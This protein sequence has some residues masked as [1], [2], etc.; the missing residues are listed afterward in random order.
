MNII[1]V[2]MTCPVIGPQLKHA[3]IPHVLKGPIRSQKSRFFFFPKFLAPK[4][5]KGKTYSFIH[6]SQM[7]LTLIEL[8]VQIE[9]ILQKL[10]IKPLRFPH[11]YLQ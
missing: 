2:C 11:Q 5:P 10:H 1:Y 7:L 3:E 4:Q 8:H 9:S 6:E